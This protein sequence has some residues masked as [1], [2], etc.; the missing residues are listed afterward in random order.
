MEFITKV[1]IIWKVG[2]SALNHPISFLFIEIENAGFRDEKSSPA[3]I[4]FRFSF[5]RPGRCFES[6]GGGLCIGISRKS[7]NAHF[8]RLFRLSLLRIRFFLLTLQQS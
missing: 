2:E 7:P 5:L 4:I 8:V 1:S 6:D 3:C